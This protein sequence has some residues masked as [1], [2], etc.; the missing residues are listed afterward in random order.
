VNKLDRE[1]ERTNID[2][3]YYIGAV[4]IF[5]HEELQIIRFT[6]LI[7]LHLQLCSFLRYWI[8]GAYCGNWWIHNK[9]SRTRYVEL[10]PSKM[11]LWC[12]SSLTQQPNFT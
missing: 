1:R 8:T 10:D 12:W 6:L 3:Q 4:Q 7:S 5:K 9:N 11:V 2:E